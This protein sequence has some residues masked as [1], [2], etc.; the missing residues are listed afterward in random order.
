MNEVQELYGESRIYSILKNSAKASP[1][2]II[3]SI[4]ADL[5]AY[6]GK[7]EPSDDITMLCFN[8]SE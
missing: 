7:A 6:R 5:V 3:N 4:Y 2:E 8:R 1:Q